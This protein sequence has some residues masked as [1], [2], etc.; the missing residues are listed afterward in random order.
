MQSTRFIFFVVEWIPRHS[1]LGA[2]K[3]PPHPRSHKRFQ[4]GLFVCTIDHKDHFEKDPAPIF[5]CA[6][7]SSSKSEHETRSVASNKMYDRFFMAVP[8]FFVIV[9][10]PL[11]PGWNA[12]AVNFWRFAVVPMGIRRSDENGISRLI[13][14]VFTFH[15]FALLVPFCGL[16]KIAFSPRRAAKCK[17]RHGGIAPTHIA[18]L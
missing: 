16:E 10:V 9:S 12:I 3:I 14:C 17:D 11:K 1:R 13:F 2:T 6:N 7:A 8:P 15:F 4:M 5:T 18:H